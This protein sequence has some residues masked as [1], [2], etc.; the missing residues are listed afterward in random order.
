MI[1]IGPNTSPIASDP[2]TLRPIAATST[3]PVATKEAGQNPYPAKAPWYPVPGGL[4]SEMLAAG[5]LGYPYAV[6]AWINHISNPI[7]AMCGFEN[8]LADAVKDVKKLPLFVSVDTFIN[9]T[10]AL[11]DYIVPDTVTYESWGIGAPWA[12]VVAHP[13]VRQRIE[14]V[15]DGLARE[16]T[17][18]ASRVARALLMAEP[19]SIDKGEITDKG[20]VNQRAVLKHRDALVTALH[21]DTAPGILKPGA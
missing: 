4:S 14:A 12:D 10:S 16:A 9:E 5:M 8:A 20:S 7:Y 15:L 19:P 2:A 13:A 11:A 18:S 21:D 3:R 1:P 6:K 17:G